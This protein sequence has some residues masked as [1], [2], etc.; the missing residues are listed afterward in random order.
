MGETQTTIRTIET[1]AQ[2]GYMQIAAL[3]D[4]NRAKEA[5]EIAEVLKE[6]GIV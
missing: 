1:V 5:R 4:Q 2:H 6:L 3:L